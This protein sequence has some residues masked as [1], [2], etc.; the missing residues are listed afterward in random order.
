VLEH[1]GDLYACDHF[2]EP[3]YLLGNIHQQNMRELVDSP[4]QRRFGQDKLDT[5]TSQCRTCRVRNQCNG[6]CPKDRFAA[7]RDG[8]AGQNYLCPGLE[9]FFTHTAPAFEAMAQLIRRGRYPA[10]LMASIAIS[11]AAGTAPEP[12]AQTRATVEAARD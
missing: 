12:V 4:K 10:E 6:G 2:V 8:E 11:D 7:S 1:N 9:L 3:R 5:L